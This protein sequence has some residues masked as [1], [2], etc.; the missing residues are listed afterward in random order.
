MNKKK[1]LI[2]LGG[3][4]GERKVSLETG[5]ACLK[6]LK[7]LGYKTSTFDPKKKTIKFN[8]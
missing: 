6:A 2:V 1:V 7:K 8:R 3:T 5:K 4:S